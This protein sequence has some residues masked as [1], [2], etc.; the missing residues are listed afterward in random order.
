MAEIGVGHTCKVLR[1][2]HFLTLEARNLGFGIREES[3]E[4]GEAPF[5]VGLFSP[6]SKFLVRNC[7]GNLL[8][9]SLTFRQVLDIFEDLWPLSSG[10]A[11][12]CPVPL[13]FPQWELGLRVSVAR[14]CLASPPSFQACPPSTGEGGLV[15]RMWFWAQQ[16]QHDLKSTESG[17]MV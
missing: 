5:L 12:R 4:E 3:L 2:K 9:L 7:Y 6:P 15:L 1:K 17:S 10:F 8:I 14:G 16:D 11:Y 13:Y